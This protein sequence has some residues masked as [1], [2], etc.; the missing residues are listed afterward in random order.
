MVPYDILLLSSLCVV[1]KE[2]NCIIPLSMLGLHRLIKLFVTLY[3]IRYG[4]IYL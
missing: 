1:L 2:Y 3:M 4:I